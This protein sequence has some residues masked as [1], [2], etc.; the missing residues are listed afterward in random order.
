MPNL[1]D[2]KIK[3]VREDELMLELSSGHIVMLPHDNNEGYKVG[4]NLKLGDVD[5]QVLN[6]DIL[7]KKDPVLTDVEVLH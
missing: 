6:N 1:I 4:D 7:L 3:E 2:A 5:V